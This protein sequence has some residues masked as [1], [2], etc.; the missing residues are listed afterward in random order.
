MLSVFQQVDVLFVPDSSKALG[1]I[2]A[3]MKFNDVQNMNYLGTNLWNT[4]DLPKRAACEDAGIYFSAGVDIN[5]L[6][7]RESEFF[8]EYVQNYN[9]EPTLVEVQAFEASRALKNQISGGA[10]GR[11][12]LALALRGLQSSPGVTGDLKMSSQREFMRPI[13]VL[14]LETG[15]VKKVE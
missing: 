8:K 1:Q 14:R 5:D 11:E 9:E 7:I 3:F 12:S 2:I 10:Q 6:A 15:I 4:S 13:N